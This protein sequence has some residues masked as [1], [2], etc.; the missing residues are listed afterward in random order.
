MIAQLLCKLKCIVDLKRKLW[1]AFLVSILV[2]TCVITGSIKIGYTCL[3]QGVE[4]EN[5]P[6]LQQS[7]KAGHPIEDQ[8]CSNHHFYGGKKTHYSFGGKIKVIIYFPNCII[9]S[10]IQLKNI[11]KEI[12][13]ESEFNS[14]CKSNFCHIFPTST[15]G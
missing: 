5:F 4:S 1:V 11:L 6:V 15:L 12:S 3:P 2:V 14:S 13:S 10:P 9:F 8:A 7:L